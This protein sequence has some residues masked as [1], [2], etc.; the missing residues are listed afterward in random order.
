MAFL[1]TSLN[2]NEIWLE[3]NA[4]GY[5]SN[6]SVYTDAGTTLATDGQ[7]VQQFNDSSG[8][9]YN[10]VQATG[11]SQPTYRASTGPNALPSL[12]F[13]G[14]ASTMA[15]TAPA[16][17]EGLQSTG[18]TVTGVI[19]TT[20]NFSGRVF[21]T[22]F[23]KNPD[24][25]DH[26]CFLQIHNG[27][28]G[29]YA[30]GMCPSPAG[31]LNTST[32]YILTYRQTQ[33]LNRIVTAA[34]ANNPILC[35]EEWFINGLKV[36]ENERGLNGFGLTEWSTDNWSLGSATGG[37]LFKGWIS[38]LTLYSRPL[39]DSELR[40]LHAYA[41]K[42]YNIPV[43]SP[44]FN[45]ILPK[46][47]IGVNFV[48][49]GNSLLWGLNLTDPVYD[50]I[51]Y[52]R[53]G[54][55][56]YTPP[57]FSGVQFRNLGVSGSKQS[58]LI[59]AATQLEDTLFDPYRHNILFSWEFTN[60]LANGS[61]TPSTM[62]TAWV[63]YCQARKARG[64]RVITASCLPRG[65][66]TAGGPGSNYSNTYITNGTTTVAQQEFNFETARLALNALFR[67]DIA[68]GFSSYGGVPYMDGW[69]D[70]GYTTGTATSPVAPPN[71]IIDG[72]VW[73]ISTLNISANGPGGAG[74][75]YIYGSNMDSDFTHWNTAGTQIGAQGIGWT[76]AALIRNIGCSAAQTNAF[77]RG[78]KF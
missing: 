13:D 24:S 1:P 20:S 77:L 11:G 42:R 31:L 12:Q 70:F 19:Q 62:Y 17:L 37:Y 45:I 32:A 43:Q 16:I 34:T 8:N 69:V 67:A 29:R 66:T 35:R 55:A 33:T 10:F 58:Y 22:W 4:N 57:D 2:N 36:F 78:G 27:L 28:V 51:W 9:S 65:E 3:V 54:F 68:D 25:S 41:G 50:V 56:G 61:G 7:T 26:P 14:T 39:E 47:Q 52:A 60:E 59:L 30:N 18:F 48:A 63:A 44:D 71:Q 21:D 23:A 49:Q 76:L 74:Q 46:E 6:T 75:Q 72:N 53:N 5:A 64:W 40:Q 38:L 73:N 15:L